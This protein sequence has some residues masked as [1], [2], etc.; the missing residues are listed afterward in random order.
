MLENIRENSQGLVAKIILGFIILTFAV[1]GIGSYTNSV[2]T[3][4]AEVNGEK[5]SQ[6]EF[7]KAYQTQRARMAQQ[8]GE[9]FETL[10]NDA[11]YMAQMRDSVVENLVN[12]L[13]VDQA[14]RD[15][16]IR[17]SDERIKQTIREMP[18]FQVE[19]QF[20]NNRYLARINQEG[21]YQSSD[22][23]DYLR[24]EMTRRQLT[25][26][27]VSSEFALPYQT[28]L[29]TTL[30]NQKRD[31]RFATISAKQFEQGV[32]VTEAE[33]NDYYLANPGRFENQE[34]VKVNY[35]ALDVNDL[36][37]DIEVNDS[38]LESY[39]QQ[40][41]VNYRQPEQRRIA[42]ILI[43]FGDDKATAKTKIADIQTRLNNGEDF[44]E[45]ANALSD[46]T[47]SGENGGDL[48]WFEAGINGEAF[49]QA[50]T[51]L[52]DVNAVTDIVESESGFHLIKLTEFKAEQ[53]KTLADVKEEIAIAVSTQKAQDKFFELQQQAA[54]LSFEF[55]DS[56]E[57]AANAVGV[58]VKTSAWLSRFGNAAPFDNAKVI[59]AAFSDLVLNERLNSDIIE[60][61]DSLVLVVRLNEYQAANTKPL[62][63]VSEQIKT[64]LVQQKSAEK[65]QLL[66]DELL[67]THK[68][69]DDIS[70]QLTANNASFEEKAAVA[71][72][73]SD[74]DASIVREAFKLPHPVADAVVATTVKLNN[75]D[76]ALIEVTA[77][78]QGDEQAPA[79]FEQQYSQQLAQA[80]YQ[81][82]VEALREQAEISKRENITSTSQL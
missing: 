82:Y 35:I 58:E 20:D 67:A 74:L 7:E 36:A 79:S 18:A 40:N 30:Q 64:I 42:H 65:A 22:F 28:S 61:S 63:Q 50:V 51:A 45:L 23:R 46:D 37:K 13:L 78:S 4:V 9:M 80:A 3:S 73:G 26:A 5:I 75:G 41:I 43:E 33:I 2:D 47:F 77:V 57:D 49:D 39:Y 16:A 53:V 38:D 71:R 48:E 66:A 17:I 14:S 6:A 68:A 32:E 52:T 81:S 25:Q 15:M 11:N 44:G 76:I 55:P 70:A 8:F 54:Q 19:G 21:F 27:L 34:K 60:V 29:L 69:G 31:I 72:Y 10:S 56:L 1:A 59:D 24:V 12:Q 62:E